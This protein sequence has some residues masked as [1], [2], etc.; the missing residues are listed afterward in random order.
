MSVTTDTGDRIA[1]P[2]RSTPASLTSPLVVAAARLLITLAVLTAWEYLPGD[3]QRF[4]ISSPSLIAEK[5]VE[6]CVDGSIWPHLAA[7]LTVMS[8][9]YVLGCAA[10][11]LTGLSLEA[12]PRVGRVVQP[13][14]LALYSLPKIALAPLF[15]IILGIGV[16]SKVALVSITVFFI[17]LNCT[18]DGLRDIDPDIVQCCELLGAGKLEVARKVLFPAILPWLFAGMRI[19]IRYAFTGTLLAELI[20]A[21]RGLGFLIEFNSGQSDATGAYAAIAIIVAFSVALTEMLAW[22]ERRAAVRSR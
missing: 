18:I 20:A 16:G 2:P 5:I 12:F 13:Y 8:L 17:L 21:N 15:I 6:W 9:G 3:A 1:L 22:I 14:I 7:T 11:M 4:W 10:G 19:S